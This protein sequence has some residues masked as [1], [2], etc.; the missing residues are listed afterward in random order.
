MSQ[1]ELKQN[2]K[3]SQQLIMTP[4]LQLAIK[5]LA[6]NN[7]ELSELIN[8]QIVENPII[9]VD[10][11]M[12]GGEKNY[13]ESNN[14]ANS[15]ANTADYKK[16]F[17]NDR[18]TDSSDLTSL[19]SENIP[20]NIQ[21]L[22]DKDD[23]YAINDYIANYDEQLYDLSINTNTDW[24]QDKNY[25][26]ENTVAGTE[27]LYEFIMK[28]VRTG[29]F[30]NDEVKLA[31]YIAGNLD[32]DGFLRISS[33]ELEK[34]AGNLAPLLDNVLFKIHKLEPVGIATYDPLSC[35]L[36]QADYFF[37]E[38]DLLKNIIKNYIKDIANGNYSK[39]VKET[40]NILENVIKSVNRLKSLAPKPAI[41]FDN[42]NNNYI[43]PDLYV[44]KINGK[45]TVFMEDNYL[46]PIRINSYYKKILNG[47][48]ISNAV[49]KD[50]VEEK[51][52]SAVWLV[53]SIKNRK[54]TILKIA[55]LIIDKQHDFFE[56]G[57]GYLKPI[58]LKTIA[59][60]L[61]LH[62][63]TVSR[64][65]SNKYISSHLGVFELKSFFSNFSFGEISP[66]NIMSK[67]KLIIEN[68]KNYGKIYSDNDIVNLLKMENIVIA[69]RTI[70]KYREILNI[71]S[72]AKRKKK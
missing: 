28:Q 64:A 8:Q 18:D 3:L 53:K 25:I 57:T 50:Y 48:L 46:P 2:L 26:I 9:D 54:E 61:N 56:K 23:T 47:E 15:D 19:N 5:M 36:F 38:D 1:I 6:M 29:D 4:R 41:N 34:Y 62:E 60:E 10:V 24:K 33:D 31:E 63:S 42:Q 43:I 12:N 13:N 68:E 52:K 45:Y 37:P 21:N 14:S 72:S 51:L 69:R 35:L 39:I 11:V 7:I 58:I 70:A 66:D 27:T 59:D 67:I 17:I 40:G 30:N 49:T 16:E 71:P 55:Q 44:E 32:S 65:T 20:E 22:N